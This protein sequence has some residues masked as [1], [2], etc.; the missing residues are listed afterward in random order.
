MKHLMHIA[1]VVLAAAVAGCS[2]EGESQL[3]YFRADAPD[4]TGRKATEQARFAQLLD[5]NAPTLLVGVESR[6]QLAGVALSADR[7]GRRTWTTPDDV[8]ISTQGGLLVATRGLS[9]DL[10]AADVSGVAPLIL[11][12][13]AGQAERFHRYLDGEYHTVFSSYVCDIENLGKREVTLLGD[14]YATTL[15]SEDCIGTT[16]AFTNLYWL[17]GTEVV[18]S[19]QWVSAGTGPLQIGVFSR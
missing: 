15:M 8:S 14:R 12:R 10:M 6:S 18:Q 2:S 7:D 3:D 17:S 19:R 13:Q 5:N 11:A 1:C 9:F 16:D 4:R